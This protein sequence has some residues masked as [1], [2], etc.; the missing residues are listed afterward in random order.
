MTKLRKLSDKRLQSR[1]AAQPSSVRLLQKRDQLLSQHSPQQCGLLASAR[2]VTCTGTGI[3]VLCRCNRALTCCALQ[4]TSMASAVPRENSLTSAP[5]VASSVSNR[6][7][8]FLESCHS[9]CL[10]PFLNAEPIM[11]SPGSEQSSTLLSSVCAAN[12][13]LRVITPRSPPPSMRQ[14]NG[15]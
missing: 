5:I 13:R 10:L 6:E 2:R 9:C 8:G 12:H 7:Y 3:Q 1:V 4:A 15:Q 11:R 14:A